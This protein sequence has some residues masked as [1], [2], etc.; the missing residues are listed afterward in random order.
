LPFFHRAFALRT[1]RCLA[2]TGSIDAHLDRHR[3]RS[4]Q[5]SLPE[6]ARR[7]GLSKH[8]T[9]QRDKPDTP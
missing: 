5:A 2:G 7:M 4:M 9:Q 1:A 3:A 6:M 8:P